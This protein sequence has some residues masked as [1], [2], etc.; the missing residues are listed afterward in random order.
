MPLKT[1]LT[2]RL[3]PTL[4]KVLGGQT[5]SEMPEFFRA[6]TLLTGVV[7]NQAD[8]LYYSKPTIAGS[9]TLTL[10][11]IGGGLVDVYGDA[12]GP[13]RLKVI[14][15]NSDLAVCPNTINLVRPA[16]NGA[17]IFL[18]AGDGEPI[19]PGGGK[20]WWAPDATGVLLTAGTGD[21]IDLVNT[22]GGNVQPDVYLIGASA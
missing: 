14:L 4:T 1:E 12:F 6:L 9:A 13:A 19:R 17:P 5:L 16:T 22:A 2:I 8:K 11:L 3:R 18:A 10:D 21:L 20:C 7:L 15:V